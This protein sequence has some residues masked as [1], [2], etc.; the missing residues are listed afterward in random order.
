MRT[1]CRISPWFF[2]LLLIVVNA[3]AFADAEAITRILKQQPSLARFDMCHGG[4][5]AEIASVA[6]TEEE[7]QQV[8][9]VF[10]P[11]SANAEIE[12]KN[13]AEAI[14]VMERIVGA[15]TATGTDRGGTFG[16]S[17][18]PG[19]LDCNDEATNSTTYMKLMNAAG[20]IH[21]H[22]ILDIKLR[23]FF[24]NGWPHSTAA[25]KDKQTGQSYAVDSWF[26]DNGKPAVVLPLDVWKS[27]WKPGDSHAH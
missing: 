8:R 23:G 19:Q 6:V 25:M 20:F 22:E 1:S 14:G 5:C 13:I 9:A 12:R 15:K 10:N 2:S 21:F 24:L 11:A 16:N 17:S 4:G 3:A 26:Y 18:Y 27:G 7:W